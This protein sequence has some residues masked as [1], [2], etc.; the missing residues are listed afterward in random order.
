MDHRW[1]LKKMAWK[2]KEGYVFYSSGARGMILFADHKSEDP[3]Y[4]VTDE[5]HSFIVQSQAHVSDWETFV[6]TLEREGKGGMFS[7]YCQF[8]MKLYQYGLLDF[9]NCPLRPDEFLQDATIPLQKLQPGELTEVFS[10][11]EG[12]TKCEGGLF[13]V[14]QY[15]GPEGNGWWPMGTTC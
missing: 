8:L 9:V 4:L 14:C 6:D 10:C 12:D 2:L 3:C 1:A 11:S 5:L 15:G 7:N 13:Y